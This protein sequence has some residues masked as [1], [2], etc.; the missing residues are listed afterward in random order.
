MKKHNDKSIKEN[1]DLL[2][3]RNIKLRKG[4]NAVRVENIYREKMG[5]VINKYTSKIHFHNETLSI[6]IL[7][8]PLKKELS[9]NHSKILKLLNA[10][11]GEELI[12]IIKI[13]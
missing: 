5:E 4:R 9:M 2:F 3:N 11:L 10:E 1:L 7:S 12:K 13:Y 8:A 6:H